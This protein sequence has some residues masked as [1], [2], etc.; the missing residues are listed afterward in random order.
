[1]DD[2]TK[3]RKARNARNAIIQA[4]VE[5]YKIDRNLLQPPIAEEV[6]MLLMIEKASI[7]A[8]RERGI[9]SRLC[10]ED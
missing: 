4:V 1:M 3:I 9:L 10:T 7:T 8:R 5:L 2:K 6:E